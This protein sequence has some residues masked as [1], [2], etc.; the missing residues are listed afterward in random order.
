MRIEGGIGEDQVYFQV[1]ASRGRGSSCCKKGQT[2]S[3]MTGNGRGIHALLP[4]LFGFLVYLLSQNNNK[5]HFKGGCLPVTSTCP[6]FCLIW[7]DMIFLKENPHVFLIPM[8]KLCIYSILV[9]SRMC[10]HCVV[11][12]AKMGATRTSHVATP[13]PSNSVWI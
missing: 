11:Q 2:H 7:N 10:V 8:V 12:D 5:Q 13:T 3:N 4:G 1:K 9:F 6:Y